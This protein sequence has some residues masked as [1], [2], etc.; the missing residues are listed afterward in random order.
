MVA[1]RHLTPFSFV[2]YLPQALNY[3]QATDAK[4]FVALGLDLS[5]L[6]KVSH[7]LYDFQ[8]QVPFAELK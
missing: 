6:S 8:I 4:T 3:T 7:R 5:T 2:S 1:G